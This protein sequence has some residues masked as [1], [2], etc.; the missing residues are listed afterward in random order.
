MIGLFE[1]LG[2]GLMLARMKREEIVE[3][4]YP[5]M[6][7]DKDDVTVFVSEDNNP[8]VEIPGVGIFAAPSGVYHVFKTGGKAVEPGIHIS[9]LS[10]DILSE[11]MKDILEQLAE[12]IRG[13]Q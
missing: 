8:Y 12:Q 5:E 6:R 7:E 1:R 9:I 11:N 2:I 10:R 4:G 13:G 3:R